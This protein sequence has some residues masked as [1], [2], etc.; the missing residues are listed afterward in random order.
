MGTFRYIRKLPDFATVAAGSMATLM[1][2]KGWTYRGI[3]L[4]YSAGGSAANEATM[5]A[6]ISK[7]RLKVNGN[8]RYEASATQLID[9]QTKYYGNAVV[10]G[11]LFVPLSRTFL[12]TMEAQDNTAWG[13]RN[14]DTF[15]IEVDIDSGATSPVLV[16]HA[17]V[18]PVANDLGVIVEGHTYTYNAS[19]AVTMEVA[20]LP[21]SNGQLVGLHIQ[22]SIVTEANL[23]VNGVEFLN[24]DIDVM[25]AAL[26][27]RPA[28]RSPVSN[29]VHIDPL[30]LNR[31]ADAWPM[32]VEDFRLKLKTSGSGAVP[33][34]VETLSAPL[35]M[36][37]SV[38][39]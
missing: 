9:I 23:T 17:E 10:D 30:A 24:T 21:K 18:D 32:M 6:D 35:G 3:I 31:V 19:G 15:A 13:T 25:H 37:S 1:A 20:D 22:T 39:R 12:K 34:F 16:A 27:R 2:P 4:K 36:P 29:W 11:M 7:V 8:T 5:K 33:I 26:K 14:V 38:R 28:N